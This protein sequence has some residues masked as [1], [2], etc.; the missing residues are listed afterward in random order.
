MPADPIPIPG[1]R[2]QRNREIGRIA[3]ESYL[4]W[5]AIVKERETKDKQADLDAA[6]TSLEDAAVK[7]SFS[8]KNCGR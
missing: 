5:W 2:S 6:D 7:L 4:E 8:S 1:G 3:A